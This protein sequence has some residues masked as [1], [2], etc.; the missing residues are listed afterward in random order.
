MLVASRAGLVCDGDFS[1]EQF[2]ISSSINNNLFINL[3]IAIL[4]SIP[5]IIFI[6]I[7]Y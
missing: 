4:L 2:Y 7:I 1:I 3:S 6:I 5:G